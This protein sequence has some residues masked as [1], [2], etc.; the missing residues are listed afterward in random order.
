MRRVATGVL[1]LVAVLIGL[2]ASPGGQ[3]ER[4]LP[5][6]SDDLKLPQGDRRV[7]VI[8]QADAQGLGSLRTRFGRAL[9]RELPG[10][11]VLEVTPQELRQLAA[12]ASVAHLS[13]DLPVSAG[14]AVTNK[15]TGAEQVWGGSESLLGLV[16]SPG[17]TGRGVGVAIVDS[18][19]APHSALGTRVV[20]RVNFVSTEP[21]GTGDPFG[22]GTH[23]AGVVGGSGSAAAGVTQSYTGGSA[24]GVRLIDV[25]VLGRDGRGLTS[26]VIA[27]INWA[28]ANR[29]RLGIRVITLALGHPVTEPSASDPLCAAVARAA[30]AGIVVVVSA[31][32]Y[33]LTSTGSPVLG[34]ITSP[35][36]SP[37]A[38][39]VGAIDTGGTLDVSD[40]QVAPYSSKGP[41]AYDLAVKPDLVAPGSRVVSLEAHQSY[42]STT[43]PAWHVAGKNRNGYLRLSGTSMAAA[44]VSGGAALLLNAQPQLSPAQVKVALQMG[45]RFMPREGL[46]ASGTGSVNFDRSLKLASNGLSSSLL[47]PINTLLGGAGGAAFRDT[48]TLIDGVYN[49]TGIALLDSVASSLFWKNAENAP[50]GVLQLLGLLNP[51]G[52]APAN[53]LVWGQ[54]ADWSESYYIVWGNSIQSPSGEYIVWGN[55]EYSEGNYIVWGN[56][57]PE[58]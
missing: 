27:G 56:H 54:V 10:A 23:V 43:Y 25:R 35:G 45:A 21:G 26:D 51:L 58:R 48:G 53:S 2:P 34:G 11:V 17:Y 18:G 19:I 38:I 31:G 52:Y 1:F 9:R 41:T 55:S 16:D 39:T 47:G 12:D 36:N 32:N 3:S 28:V 50:W 57:I 42:L 33:G 30:D 46:V 15:V 24:P 44:V 29:A 14:M 8:A 7:R 5:S 13:G 40:D 37:F 20:E 4:P 49:R 6:L 22:H